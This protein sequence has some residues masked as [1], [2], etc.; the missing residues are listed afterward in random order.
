MS[1]DGEDG[2]REFVPEDF[3]RLTPSEALYVKRKFDA[4]AEMK[5]AIKRVL[6]VDDGTPG[7]L[8]PFKHYKKLKTVMEDWLNVP[9]PDTER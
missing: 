2:D 9:V 4:A 1:D 5:T 8:L 7:G 3:T 6:D